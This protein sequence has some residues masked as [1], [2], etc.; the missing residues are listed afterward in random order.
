[1]QRESRWYDAWPFWILGLL[2]VIVSRIPLWD[3]LAH[4]ITSRVPPPDR[5]EFVHDLVNQ[6]Y[7]TALLEKMFRLPFLVSGLALFIVPALGL[8]IAKSF[9]WKA[10]WREKGLAAKAFAL[11]VVVVVLLLV[12]H[13]GIHQNVPISPDEHLYLYQGE[14][15]S[16]FQLSV[17]AHENPDFFKYAF[18]ATH[19]GK[20]FGI[21]PPGFPMVLA[22]G[23][24]LHIPSILPVLIGAL[25]PVLVF[26]LMA[27]LDRP[28][29]GFF[30]A[31]LLAL[32][33][34]FFIMGGTFFSHPASLVLVLL[35]AYGVAGISEKTG[36]AAYFLFGLL[37]AFVGLVHHLDVVALVPFGLLLVVRLWQT[38]SRRLPSLVCLT[39]G[40]L[41]IVALELGYH[42]LLLGDP[43]GQP[44]IIYCQ[45]ENHLTDVYRDASL[46]H[47]FEAGAMKEALGLTLT[48]LFLLNV[49][50]FPLSL[51]L[52]LPWLFGKKHPVERCML[53]AF[54]LTVAVYFVYKPDGGWEL[55][56]RFYFHLAGFLAI[57][58]VDGLL[59]IE[60]RLAQAFPRKGRDVLV[61]FV[62][63]GFCV[64]AG[65]VTGRSLYI[66]TFADMLRIP[67]R[68]VEAEGLDKAL[69]FMDVKGPPRTYAWGN[70]FWTRNSPGLDGPIVFANDLGEQ[71]ASL[72]ADFP[73]Y[74]PRRLELTILRYGCDD[75]EPRLEPLQGEDGGRGRRPEETRSFPDK[76]A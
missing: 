33:P 10:W 3:R 41:V 55:G 60:A 51:L 47:P 34:Y 75:F 39:A 40:G 29:T 49:V 63:L 58:V 16:T 46:F 48:R 23:Y 24:W 35:F 25:A 52:A 12:S 53:F 21:F 32:S 31:V 13:F 36:A 19:E 11:Y 62:L 72:T 9:W 44:Y 69:V 2:A 67:H 26:L 20:H 74:E 66:Q 18:M 70:Y 30:A 71:N 56:P 4:R 27:R 15:Y 59:R 37:G 14:L 7:V 42:A 8:W 54:L 76:E 43:L 1:M 38:S 57:A 50:F 73:D 6:P 65:V 68:L 28:K 64:N 17:E 61:G 5:P 22:L 45:Q